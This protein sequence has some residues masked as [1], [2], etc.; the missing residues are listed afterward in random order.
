MK[1]FS[2]A[3]IKACDAYTIHA[4]AIGSID[5][6]ER[7]AS[8]CAQYIQNRF[9]IDTPFVVLCGM[10]NNGA[11]GL[12][13][14]RMLQLCN[15]AV[16]V[17]VL[18]HRTEPSPENKI[19]QNKILKTNA[20]LIDYIQ[21]GNYIADLPEHV[22]VIDAILGIGLNKPLDPWLADFITQIN[23][24]NNYTIALDIPTGMPADTIPTAD[25]VILKADL[26]LSF[27]FY[28]R[29]FLHPETGVYCGRIRLL[30]IGLHKTFI[31]ATH[32]HY[33]TIEQ[34]QVCKLIIPK[35]RFSYKNQHGH[36]QIFAGGEGTY[37]AAILSVQSALRSGVGLVT[38]AVPAGLVPV[39]NQACPE[40]MTDSSGE[41][42]IEQIRIKP[43]A[44]AYAAGMGIGSR[45]R[46]IEAF[47]SF[48]EACTQACVLDADALN[49]MA[50]HP[51]LLHRI[52]ENSILTPHVGEC[53][54]LFGKAGNSMQRVEKI[55]MEAMKYKI[56]IVLKGHH[57][58]IAGPE[59]D[60]F[61]NLNGNAGMAKAGS[62][63]VLSGILGGLL[64]QGY[65]ALQASLIGVCLHGL[66]GD[67]AAEKWG[68]NAMTATDTIKSLSKAWQTL[69]KT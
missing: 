44:N 8:A 11:D 20:A 17:F 16:K 58:V 2:A 21:A 5:L 59:G 52:P 40:V 31:E 36:L 66:A 51:D 45:E 27:Q 42:C 41:T 34:E 7:A 4:N 25:A 14:A 30:D 39:L 1:I 46:T 48:I 68:Q 53:D 60:C 38:A 64:A 50:L 69:L 55:R 3:Q 6:V 56:C 62:G 49:I 37:G 24:R 57:T 65:T 28:K 10:G 47:S 29:S 22:V 54:R 61:Y 35:S 26:T 63:D 19:N 15:Y 23:A 43:Q 32:T 18:E 13:L 9:S 67:I 33:H 12:A